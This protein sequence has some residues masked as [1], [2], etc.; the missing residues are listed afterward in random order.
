MSWINVHIRI[1]LA[2]ALVHNERDDPMATLIKTRQLPSKI[3]PIER[4]RN[5]NATDPPESWYG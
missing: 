1:F 3:D 2:R 4:R 5:E